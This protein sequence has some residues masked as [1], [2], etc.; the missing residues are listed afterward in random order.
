MRNHDNHDS[1]K[2]TWNNA[3]LAS[4]NTI[5]LVIFLP[6]RGERHLTNTRDKGSKYCLFFSVL[7]ERN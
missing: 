2:A 1:P 4:N 7:K 3:L 6:Q 5:T